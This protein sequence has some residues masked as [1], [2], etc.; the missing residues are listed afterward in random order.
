MHF[1]VEQS[2]AEIRVL[3][4]ARKQFPKEPFA[5]FFVAVQQLT[6]RCRRQIHEEETVEILK[7]NMYYRLREALLFHDINTIEHL[8]LL[9]RKLEKIWSEQNMRRIEPRRVNEIEQ[10]QIGYELEPEVCR[11]NYPNHVI[12]ECNAVQA[13]IS[14]ARIA[15][16]WDTLSLIASPI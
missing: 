16:R 7:R 14:F 3:I 5:D 11:H 15:K 13:S 9:C 6:V 10:E 2:D 8:H 4:E 1:A 12:K